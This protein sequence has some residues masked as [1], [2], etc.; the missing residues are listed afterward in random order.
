[1]QV[2]DRAR[3]RLL[4]P[5]Q[6]AL[7]IAL[8]KTHRAIDK[9]DPVFTKVFSHL[10][11]KFLKH[12][13]WNVNLGD[14]LS[15]R[16]RGVEPLVDFAMVV[17]RIDTQLVCVLPVHLPIGREIVVCVSLECLFLICVSEIQELPPV[18]IR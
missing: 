12:R 3:V 8:D 5:R 7:I 9:L 13:S 14:H 15:C 1:M 6:K 18:L 11:E 2:K 10:I 16:I 4:R 17:V